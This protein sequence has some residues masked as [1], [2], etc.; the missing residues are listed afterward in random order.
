MSNFRSLFASKPVIA[1][2]HLPP[3]PGS[4]RWGDDWEAVEAS[5]IHDADALARAGVDGIIVE[6]YGDA[7]FLPGSVEPVTVAAMAAIVTA[8]RHRVAG[9][10]PLGVNVL[11][12]DARAALSICAACQ[13]QFIRVNVHVGAVV[14]DQGTIEGRAWE[15][16]RLRRNL[17]PWVAILADVGVKHAQ[18]LAGFDIEGEA[19]DAVE[20]GL[21]DAL[22]VTGDATGSETDSD[23]I[24]AVR[25]AG[26]APVLVGSGVTLE[27]VD[28]AMALSDG[29]IVGSALKR[30]G[31]AGNSVDAER[32]R[33]FLEA[34]RTS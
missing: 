2:I 28:D 18:P 16:A 32:T 34:A 24:V 20:R 11:R 5:A 23:D 1:V 27:T 22:I 17:A 33:R 7:P 29:I 13:A 25:R 31:R 10:P 3:L 21:A 26:S 4:P 30:D 19:R 15:T 9:L 6:N 14:A 8:I 12:N